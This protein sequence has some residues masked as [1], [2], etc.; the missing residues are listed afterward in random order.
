MVSDIMCVC[1]GKEITYI[2]ITGFDDLFPYLVACSV[3]NT[4]TLVASP[5]ARPDTAVSV[6]FPASF[7]HLPDV[8]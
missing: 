4:S 2:T 3:T 7:K 5:V 6:C 1:M 8:R